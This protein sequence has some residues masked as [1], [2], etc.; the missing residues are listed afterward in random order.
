MHK[1]ECPTDV[2]IGLEDLLKIFNLLVTNTTL[3]SIFGIQ[4]QE[5]DIVVSEVIIG[6]AEAFLPFFGHYFVAN[7]MVSGHI[8]EGHL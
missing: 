1:Y 7:I 4:T 6:L 3:T 5:Q 2:S 8:K